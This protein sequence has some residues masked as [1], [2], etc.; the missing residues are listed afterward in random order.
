MHIYTY[1][2][3]YHNSTYTCRLPTAL[4]LFVFGIIVA[5]VR[6]VINGKR[7]AYNVTSWSCIHFMYV[8]VEDNSSWM[9]VHV[10]STVSGCVFLTV[11]VCVHVQLCVYVSSVSI[12]VISTVS[13][14]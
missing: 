5:A 7:V 4:I 13:V 12:C 10:T 11:S 9:I 3:V 6:M 8:G 1:I 2:Y 14:G